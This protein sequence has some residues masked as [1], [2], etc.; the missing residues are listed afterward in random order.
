MEDFDMQLEFPDDLFRLL[1]YHLLV[2]LLRQDCRKVWALL[3][4]LELWTK[5]EEPQGFVICD[6]LLGTS[7]DATPHV[8]MNIRM[9]HTYSFSRKLGC[10]YF[11]TKDILRWTLLFLISSSRLLLTC[12]RPVKRIRRKTLPFSH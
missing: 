1:I 2:S 6:L 5:L 9:M 4:C 10:H 3:E 11:I 12:W 8:T 7:S